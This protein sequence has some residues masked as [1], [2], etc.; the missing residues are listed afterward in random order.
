MIDQDFI[1]LIMNCQKYVKKDM[2]K[3]NPATFKVLSRN[4]RRK[5]GLRVSF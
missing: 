2:V 1:M 3:T 5:F 4:R